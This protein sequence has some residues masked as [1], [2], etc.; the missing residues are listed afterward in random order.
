MDVWHQSTERLGQIE[1]SETQDPDSLSMDVMPT[2][3]R[4]QPI[5]DELEPCNAFSKDQILAVGDALRSL[6]IS[7]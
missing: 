6:D 7:Q 2:H 3:D 5:L 1:G 4:F